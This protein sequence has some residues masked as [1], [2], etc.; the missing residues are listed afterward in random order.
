MHSDN[1]IYTEILSEVRE[2]GGRG[3]LGDAVHRRGRR[4]P[5][6]AGN[7]EEAGSLTFCLEPWAATWLDPSPSDT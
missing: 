3:N 5:N 7:G 6:I 1:G 4:M 2:R